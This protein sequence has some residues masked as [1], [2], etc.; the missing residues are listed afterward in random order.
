[1]FKW[2]VAQEMVPVTT[3]QALKTLEGLRRGEEGVR[4]S[5]PVKPVPQEHIDAIRHHVSRQVWAMVQL[6][7]LTG[8]R[9]QEVTLMRRADMNMAEQLWTYR[10][11]A[12]KTEHHDRVREIPLGPHAQKI[13]RPFLKFDADAYLF[14]PVEAQK[15]RNEERRR[16]RES[17]MTPSQS[18]RTP[19]SRRRRAPGVHYTSNTYRHAIVAAGKRAEV[20]RWHPH[21]L[22]HNFATAIRAKYGIETARALLGHRNVQT[23][24]LYAEQDRQTASQVALAVG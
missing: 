21:Q 6:Q 12:H 23:A 5:A 2:A 9:S 19:K 3:H 18:R 7:L 17:P 1:M 11:S 16:N 22:R 10:P 13:L 20:P 14:S 15:E 4:E 8:M 24:E